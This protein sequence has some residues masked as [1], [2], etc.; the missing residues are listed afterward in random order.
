MEH[1]VVCRLDGCN[2]I[3]NFLGFICRIKDGSDLQELLQVIYGADTSQMTSGKTYS[4]G[5]RGHFLLEG[6]GEAGTCEP[7]GD[8]L[9]AFCLKPGLADNLAQKKVSHAAD[10]GKCW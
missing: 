2:I 1:K 9:Y 10:I 4:I 7:L 5:I 8:C 6:E 3:M